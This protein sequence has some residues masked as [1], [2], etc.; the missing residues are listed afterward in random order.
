MFVAA[1]C[2]QKF[3]QSRNLFGKFLIRHT[4]FLWANLPNFG[5]LGVNL[6]HLQILP[7]PFADPPRSRCLYSR[8]ALQA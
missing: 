7:V 8:F 2:L 5:A 1:V 6:T 4:F 3:R